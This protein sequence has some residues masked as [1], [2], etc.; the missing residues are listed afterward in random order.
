M[1]F[2]DLDF[3][4]ASGFLAAPSVFG[5]LALMHDFLLST[6]AIRRGDNCGYG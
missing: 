2:A 4:D 5:P 3:Y 1:G 6:I